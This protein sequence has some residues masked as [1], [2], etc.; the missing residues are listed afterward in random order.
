VHDVVAALIALAEHPKAV[1]QVFNI[2]ND[3]EIT[4]RHLA[5]FTSL[6]VEQAFVS[7]SEDVMGTVERMTVAGVSYLI[8]EVSEMWDSLLDRVEVP[9]QP[10]RRIP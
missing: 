6:D 2:G 9:P 1:G 3:S 5:E 10:F 4:I 8:E 7:S